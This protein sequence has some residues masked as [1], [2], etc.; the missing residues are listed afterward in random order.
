MAGYWRQSHSR[1]DTSGGKV[2]EVK[3]EER[4][5]TVP[6]KMV[7]AGHKDKKELSMSWVGSG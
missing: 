1:A 7:S 3:T 2:K 5:R 4:N 6:C